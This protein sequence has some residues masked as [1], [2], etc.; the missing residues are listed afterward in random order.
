[1]RKIVIYSDFDGVHNL[2]ARLITT[3]N[4]EDT[5]SV[6]VETTSSLLKPSQDVYYN[7]QV[8]DSFNALLATGLFD[9]TWHTTWNDGDSIIHAAEKIGINPG[10]AE[11]VISD[12]DFNHDAKGKKDWTEWKARYIIEDQKNNPRP[13]VWIDDEA[14]KFWDLEILGNV[15]SPGLIIQPKSRVGLTRAHILEIIEF[16]QKQ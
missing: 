5:V 14:T 11:V 3:E 16:A 13:F 2:P 1:M 6:K 8:R 10:G 15:R 9:L 7:E 12:P 4:Q